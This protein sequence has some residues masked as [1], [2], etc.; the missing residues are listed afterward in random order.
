WRIQALARQRAGRRIR[1]ALCAALP[2]RSSGTRRAGPRRSDRQWQRLPALDRCAR[3]QQSGRRAADCIRD[4]LAD[5]AGLDLMRQERDAN[6]LIGRTKFGA[7]AWDDM[8]NDPMTR[9]ALLLF[10]ISKHFP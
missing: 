7:G 6:Q 9:D 8:Y 5:A 3:R 4:L 1:C 2:A 10:I